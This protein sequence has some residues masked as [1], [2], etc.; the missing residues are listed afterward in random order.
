MNI[1][2]AIEKAIAEELTISY[3][4]AGRSI[5]GDNVVIVAQSLARAV[6]FRNEQEVH[7][8]FTKARDTEAIPIQGTLKGIVATIR[9][10]QSSNRKAISWQPTITKEQS[11]YIYA[12]W[13]LHG[14]RMAWLT[15]EKARATVEAFE[16]DRNNREFVSYQNGWTH[17]AS[18]NVMKYG[19]ATMRTRL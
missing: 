6:D 3:M 14:T 9:E 15:D 2:K 1:E 7:A 19:T 5:T 18:D 17:V 12:W 4:Q 8:A 11:D 16:A 13:H 10:K